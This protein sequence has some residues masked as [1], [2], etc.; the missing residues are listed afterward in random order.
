MTTFARFVLAFLVLVV[1]G[2]AAAANSA[3]MMTPQAVSVAGGETQ[4][5]TA[6]FFDALGRPVVGDV[7]RFTN[8]VCGTFAGGAFFVDARTDANGSASASFT[9]S[10]PAGITCWVTATSG[11]TLRWDVHTYQPALVTLSARS[12]PATP[13]PSQP[14][15]LIVSANTG[16]YKL[17]N[18]EVGARVVGGT[19]SASIS[20]AAM[21]T[22]GSGGAEFHVIP[23]TR[24]GDYEIELQFRGRTQRIAMTAPAN[25]LQDMWWAGRAE[26][27]WGV[28]VVQHGDTLFSVIYA[29]DAAGKPIWYV[30]PG[31]AWNASRTSYSGPVYTPRGAPYSTYDTSQFVAGA[32]V[33][34]VTLSFLDANTMSLDYTIDG[35]TGRKDIVRQEFGPADAT[36]AGNV[37]DMWWGG[38]AQNGWGIAV[39]QQ[40]R[41]LFSVWFT[42]DASGAPTWFVMPNGYWSDASTYEGRIY[43]TTGAPW[44]GRAYDATALQVSDVGTF[45]LCFGYESS[46]FEYVIDG[47]SGTMGLARQPF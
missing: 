45:R 6:R 7:V 40:Y 39:L 9:A 41:T 14:Y 44:V 29:Y 18:V 4:V 27:G 20:P 38:L 34:N 36:V 5:F 10:N 19:A 3:Q 23:D 26:N 17:F 22:G 46:S 15:T 37:G 16:A 25:P 30:M 11:V 31:G 28:S 13:R 8:D 12:N 24:L 32:P 2:I 33:G 43:R 42:Y 1:P 21:S 47:K 35:T